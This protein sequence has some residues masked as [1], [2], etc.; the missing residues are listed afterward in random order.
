MKYFALVPQASASPNAL[1]K[2][3]AFLPRLTPG[4]K[5]FARFAA[6]FSVLLLIVA[7][8]PAQT[9]VVTQH[10]DIGRTGQNRN[11]T[12]LTPANVNSTSFG[13]LFSYA[14]DGRAYAQPL[15]V[16]GLTMGSG[17]AQAGTRHNVVF[18]ATEHD[19]VY[20]FDAD[21]NG[22]PNSSPL[23]QITLLDS[24]HGAASGA[25]TVP[26]GDVSTGDITPEIGITGTP[27]ID[28]NTNTMYVVGKTKENGNYVQRLHALDITTGN[29]KS[30]SPVALAAQVS[31]NGN[32]SSGGVLKFD[33][34]WESNR[35]GLL[36]LNGNVYIGFAAHGDNGPWHG[37]ILAYNAASLQQS[38]VFCS[39]SNGSGSGIWM[40][41]AGL[42]ADT[43]NNGRL[44]VA[45]GNG[46]F[47]ANNPPY[48]NSMSYGDDIVRLDV[49]NGSMNV[50]DHFTP[51]NQADLNGRDADVA[52]G[53]VLLLPDQTAGGHTR[54][55]V[56]VGKEGRIYLI[57]RDNLGGYNSSSDNIVQEIPVNPSTSFSIN[58]LWSIP[59]YWNGNLYF[60]GNGDNLTAFSFANGRIGSITS[61]SAE[62]SSFPGATPSISSNGNNNGIVWDVLTSAYGSSGPA[63]LLAHNAT[64]VGNTLYSSNQNLSRDNPGQATKFVVPTVVNGKVYVGTAN[65]LSVFGLLS[66]T[67]QAA[68]PVLNPGGQSFSGSL[69]VSITDSTPG[70]S[71]YYT[72]NG[73]TPT[74]ASTKY[75][76]PVTVN[77]TETI[78]AIASASGFVQSTVSSETYNLLTQVVAPS[79]SPVAGSFSTAQSVTLSSDT[80]GASI[81]YTTD[82]STPVP[83]TGSTKPYTSAISVASTQTIKAVATLAGLTTS[84]VSSATYTIVVGGTGI[85]FVDGFSS[86]QSVMTFNGT[87]VLNDTRLQLTNGGLNQAGSAWFNT[88]V[89][90]T[91]F[92]NDFAFQLENADADGITFTIQ[93]NGLNS[94]GGAGGS[95]G[96][97]G[98]PKSVAIKF[99][100]Y[101]NNGEGDDSTGIYQ[102]GAAPNTPFVDLTNSAID[103][104]NGD[105]FSVH[106][107]YNGTTLAM[108][109]TDGVTGAV[110]SNSWAI[111]LPQIIGSNTAYVGFTGGTGGTTASQ[112]IETWTYLSN[113]GAPQ[114]T[115]TPTFS[116]A[117]GTYLGT[118][119]VTISDATAGAAIFYTTNGST[120]ATT[121]GGSTL[122]YNG[123]LTVT[124]TETVKAIA[125]SST[126][127]ASPV[128][129]AT[130]S[131]EQQATAP[132]F[133]P[134]GGTYASAQ[135]VTITSPTPGAAIYYTA[136]GSTPT[137]SSILYTGP[138]S[139]AAT[140]TIKAIAVVS[141]FFNSAISTAV[142]TISGGGGSAVSLGG[143]FVA[144]SMALN[145]SS[146]LSGTKLRLTDGGGSEAG[147]AWYN[148]PL[149][150]QKFTSSFSMQVTPASAASADG[151][152]FTIQGNSTTALGLPGGGLGYGPDNTGAAV[153]PTNP[154]HNSVAVKFDLYDNNGEGV[155]STGLYVN[156]AS[157]TTPSVDLTG[158]GV[159]LHSGHVMNVQIGYDGINLSLTI[160]DPTVNSAF[161]HSW[162]I[163]IP[164]TIGGN[165]AYVGFTAGTG[166]QTA[167]QDVL[168]WTFIS[169]ATAGATATPV[170][171]PGSGTFASA[172]SVVIT[173]GTAGA[174]MYYTL[175]GSQPTAS[176]TK[177]GGA[178]SVGVTTTVK[179]I[180]VANGSTSGTATSNITIQPSGSTAGIN[181]SSGFT[182][183]GM[184]LNGDAVING[185]RLQLTDTSTN[186]EDSSAFWTQKVDIQNFTNDF[187]FQI[188]TPFADGLTF[189]IQGAGPTALGGSGGELGYGHTSSGTPGIAKSVAVKFDIYNN[190]GEGT[191][192][193]GMY[194][195]GAD[196]IGGSTT[197]GGGVSLQSGDIFAVHM[198]YDGSIL[199]M[200]ITDTANPS[201]TFTTSW[202]VNITSAVGATSAYVG[203]T[204]ATG[205][206]VANQQIVTWSFASGKPPLVFQTTSLNSTSSGPGIRLFSYPG[207]PD[208][209]GTILDAT[210]A[211]DNIVFTVAV[212]TAGIY[213]VKVAYKQYA[214]RGIMQTAVNSTNLGAPVDQ[215][216]AAAD[217]YA[218]SDLGSLNF[219]SAGNYVFRFTVVGKNAASSG[220]TISFDTITLTPQ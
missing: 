43:V 115:A 194:I 219:A 80:P 129:S 106:M 6:A 15:Y 117:A 155:N 4:T 120:P 119:T 32:G 33:T 172:Q 111:N 202:P 184:Q 174:A 205:G 126:L 198:T 146:A 160:T 190:G 152:T 48:T 196:P 206:S 63:V 84:P 156:G 71:I 114:A 10:N 136:D 26:N 88:P 121:A 60:W 169:S 182:A 52:S 217:A 73:S 141:G 40:S 35:P 145:G 70:A 188:T 173:D 18:I 138:V 130:F 151:M 131:I 36:L 189:T 158:S 137:T 19:S 149:N 178:F 53:G 17:S 201:Q 92:T 1:A 81:Y 125:K 171:I 113:A 85:N 14:I 101:N 192:S 25:T 65:L 87:T 100:L 197:L 23:W 134:G 214:I 150:I 199:T 99:D 16:S 153:S 123:P 41:G 127:A 66:P 185:N 93:N 37:W 167:I 68:A 179:A 76:G 110:F 77:G 116:P 176:S 128:A 30:G 47:N 97:A 82:G 5:R 165:S 27:V 31:G 49:N 163:N 132:I 8:T 44:F 55:M 105:T 39:T 220:Y 69:S 159:D 208:G 58:G 140:K 147:A 108:N 103:L 86:S 95:L 164:A 187:N 195:N 11:E 22:G 107:T 7:E 148:S 3:I 209:A 98:L 118:Q 20:A 216:I 34:K 57:D 186:F 142:Y 166:G 102:N 213:D 211:G 200:T 67:Q 183:N 94:L 143:G 75:A 157:P 212:P 64:N 46:A 161:T 175:D 56:Q 2:K 29:E 191:N 109:I 90:I 51:L 28:T 9:N 162:P 83:G 207:F 133:S 24:A 124:G 72:T 91:N 122:S 180:A 89:N 181:F 45:T 78:N 50:G 193:T 12:I 59:A 154:L 62:N 21:S 210:A 54:L 168:N 218:V 203:F 13:K 139:V 135:S 79:F 144:G 170:I 215:F 61:S 112:K 96:Y 38:G 204:G 42:A 74:T 104:H 177:Y